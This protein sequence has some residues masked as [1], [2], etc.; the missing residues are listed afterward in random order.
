MTNILNNFINIKNLKN[1]YCKDLS[2]KPQVYSGREMENTW[3]Y[4][5][6]SKEDLL[7]L[8]VNDAWSDREKEPAS[9]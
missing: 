8:Q 2:P 4:Q 7:H 5:R 3:N 1:H 6:K 9:E